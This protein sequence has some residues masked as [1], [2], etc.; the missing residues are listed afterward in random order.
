MYKTALNL[1]RLFEK[2]SDVLV[3]FGPFIIVANNIL[4]KTNKNNI[5]KSY[6][7]V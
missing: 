5:V 7:D 6:F 2:F 4:K 3:F 1:C